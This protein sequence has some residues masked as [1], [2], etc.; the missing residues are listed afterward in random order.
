MNEFKKTPR[1]AKEEDFDY[2]RKNKAKIL[3][4]RKQ[5]ATSKTGDNVYETNLNLPWRENFRDIINGAY[6]EFIG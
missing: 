5:I 1:Q 3:L 2:I 6:N 4:T